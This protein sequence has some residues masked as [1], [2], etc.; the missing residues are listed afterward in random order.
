[1]L[2]GLQC[3]IYNNNKREGGMTWIAA[4]CM[5]LKYS[6]EQFKLDCYKFKML[7]I[8]LVTTKEATK[9]YTA[10]KKKKSKWYSRKNSIKN[11]ERDS[12]ET[13]E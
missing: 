6:W 9:K 12:W 5:L 7:K 11:K 13:G 10:E 8:P 2:L 4:E 1:M 3:V